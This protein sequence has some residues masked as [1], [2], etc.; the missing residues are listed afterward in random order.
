MI[1]PGQK[2]HASIAFCKPTYLP[3]AC[4]LGND[5]TRDW[6]SLV[7]SGGRGRIDWAKKWEDMLEMDIFD[8]DAA[9]NV[10]NKLTMDYNDD[11]ELWLHHLSVMLWTCE[12]VVLTLKEYLFILPH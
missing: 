11:Y 5:P 7:N 12:S 1:Q 9:N 4:L 10:V 6:A 8:H 2:I 3:K